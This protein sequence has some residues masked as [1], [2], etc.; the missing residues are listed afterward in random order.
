M[1]HFLE[2]N[3]NSFGVGSFFTISTHLKISVGD[4]VLYSILERKSSSTTSQ[5]VVAVSILSVDIV[6]LPCTTCAKGKR[7][8][9]LFSLLAD[10]N[11][12]WKDSNAKT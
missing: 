3:N 4:A 9:S 1:F 11:G 12:A 2:A 7:Q 5:V 10:G 8:L 6:I